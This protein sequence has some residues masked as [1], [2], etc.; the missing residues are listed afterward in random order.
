MSRLASKRIEQ[1]KPLSLLDERIQKH[2]IPRWPYQPIFDR[3]IVLS[4]PAE[5]ES[6]ET[7]VKGGLI[8]KHVTT[9]K[10]QKNSTARAILLAAGLGAMDHLRGHGVG[11][12]HYVWVS[13]LSP[14]A[15]TVDITEDG[16]VQMLFLRSGNVV[17]SE[18]LLAQC[19]SGSVAITIDKADG[20][21][22][23]T[24]DGVPA[25]RFDPAESFDD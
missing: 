10:R 23:F 18:D 3:I 17:G 11:V 14:W 25:P 12:G 5:A 19:E 1:P 16:E 15:H 22:Q 6:R 4:I 13:R 8:V 20:R 21:H 24:F 2:K 9:E 7:F